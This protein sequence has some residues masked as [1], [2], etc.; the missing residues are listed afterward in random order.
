M[1]PATRTQSSMAAHIGIDMQPTLLLAI[2][3]VIVIVIVIVIGAMARGAETRRRVV[4]RQPRA[5]AFHS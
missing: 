1:Q 3:I 4:A 2:S 5:R